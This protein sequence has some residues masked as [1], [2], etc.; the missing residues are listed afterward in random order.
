MDARALERLLYHES[1]LL[2]VFGISGDLRVLQG[3]TEPRAR[4][5]I[6]LFAYRIQR[7]IGSLAPALGGP[8][9]SSSRPALARTRRRCASRSALGWAGLGWVGIELAA[10]ANASGGPRLSPSGSRCEA[11]AIATNEELVIARHVLQLLRPGGAA[12]LVGS[13]A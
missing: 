4:L 3:S 7:E 10:K 13:T 5:T 8:D 9:A 2:G 1:G 12:R 6:E 11:W